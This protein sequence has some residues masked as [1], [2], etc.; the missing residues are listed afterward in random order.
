MTTKEYLLG[1]CPN[2]G[3]EI[4]DVF[5]MIEYTRED[6]SIGIYADCPVCREIVTPH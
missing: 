2:C 6:G 3:E 4:S 1:C 5:K